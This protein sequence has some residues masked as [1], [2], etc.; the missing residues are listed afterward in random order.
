MVKSNSEKIKEI[1][2]ELNSHTKKQKISKEIKIDTS[3]ETDNPI[4]VKGLSAII[5]LGVEK[6]AS[7]IHIEPLKDRTRIRY[8]IDGILYEELN[9]NS[10]LHSSLISRLKIISKLDITEKKTPQDGKFRME[11]EGKTIDFR[12]SIV[13]LITGEKGVIRI[14]DSESYNFNLEN[15]GL[16]LD[17]YTKLSNLINKKNGIIL[18]CGPTGSGKSSLIYSILKKLNNGKVNISTVEDPV[19]YEI[20]G[21][22]QVQY[23]QEVGR[24]FATVLKAYL[25]QDPDILMIGEIRDYET[26]EI[27]VKSALTGHLV[28]STLHTY[29]T[30]SGIFRLLNIGIE[31]YMISASVIGIVAQRLVRK[32]CPHCLTLDKDALAKLAILKVDINS[33]KNKNFYTS[34]GCEYCNYTGYRGRTAIFE[35]LIVDD[36]IKTLIEKGASIHEFQIYLRNKKINTIIEDGIDKCLNKITSLDEII[37]QC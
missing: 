31:K 27:G 37:R 21:I 18:A 16:K 17:D 7:D 22:N 20:E 28:L 26:A 36:E 19:E 6:K 5:L 29:D 8:R 33:Y 13:P 4:V 2:K 11:I 1:F 12:V 25:R 32:L 34:V 9:F 10:S 30:V 35:L 23:N 3:L 15:L 24:D 14:L